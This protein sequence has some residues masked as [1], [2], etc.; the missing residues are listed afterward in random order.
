M[1]I[2]VNQKYTISAMMNVDLTSS[3]YETYY[4]SILTEASALEISRTDL[5]FE[6]SRKRMGL[7]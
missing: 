1:R 6:W 5:K 2:E 3:P 7:F 4:S